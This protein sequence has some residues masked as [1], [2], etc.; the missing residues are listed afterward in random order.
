MEEKGTHAPSETEDKIPLEGPEIDGSFKDY[1]RIFGY[2]DSLD[3][4]LN[5]VAFI[6]SVG[7]GATL[8]LMTLVFGSFM[9][10]PDVSFLPPL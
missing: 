2:A 5:A 3:W 6:A 1:L 9:F 10:L 4:T 7:A 8:P